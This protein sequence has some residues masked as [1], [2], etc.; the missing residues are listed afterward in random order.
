MAYEDETIRDAIDDF[1]SHHYTTVPIINRRTGRYAGT[2][3][4]GDLLRHIGSKDLGV[5]AVE[6]ERNIMTVKRNRDYQAVTID[7]TIQELF[8]TAL[9]QNFV[10]VVDDTDTFIGIV[11]RNYI[12]GYLIDQYKKG[13]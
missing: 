6:E 5:L 4:E 1:E 11:T 9:N 8:E 2:I 7:A 13:I 10:P 12:L 3:C